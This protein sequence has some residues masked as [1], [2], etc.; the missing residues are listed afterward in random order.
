MTI[1]RSAGAVVLGL[2]TVCHSGVAAFADTAG[3]AA[4]SAD[5]APL[6]RVF[7]N[8]GRTLV[9]YG[10]FARVGDRVVFSMPTSASLDNPQLHLVDLPTDR[11]DWE[12]TITYAESARASRYLAARAETDY[13]LL[14]N[15][16]A[17]A[18]SD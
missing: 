8:D 11:V 17:K 18:L 10:E 9:S 6:F 14:T 3:D 5:S 12:R 13:T 4:V 16:I 2:L 15:D 1:G 7:L